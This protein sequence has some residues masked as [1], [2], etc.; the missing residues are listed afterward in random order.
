MNAP[1]EDIPEQ[2][3]P[4]D[5]GP[6]HQ[7]RTA[8]AKAGLS[9][10][11]VS[12]RL[13]L[14][15]RTLDMLE[16]EDFDDLPAPT[17]IRG[18]L[19]SYARLLGL[20]PEPI[21]EAFDRQ[22]YGPPALIADI[23]HR[24]EARSTDLWVVVL[25]VFLIALFTVLAAVWYQTN[26]SGDFAG[27]SPAEPSSASPPPADRSDPQA[28]NIGRT[29][30]S[31]QKPGD[32][33]SIPRTDGE[34]AE[35]TQTT[36]AQSSGSGQPPQPAQTP[37]KTQD[38]T[39]QTATN[40][41][42]GERVPDRAAPSEAS[43]SATQTDSPA[44]SSREALATRQTAASGIER[45]TTGT[46]SGAV[47]SSQ[48]RAA[49]TANDEAGRGPIDTVVMQFARDAWVEIYDAKGQRLYYNLARAGKRVEVEGARPMRVLLGYV[50][51]VQVEYNG[52]PFDFSSYISKGI[53]RFEMRP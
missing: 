40:T 24:S 11:E 35:A 20:P 39:L 12:A 7:L 21:V 1:S 38:G 33:D 47:P 8:R 41:P 30:R 3:L 29:E 43:V 27:T 4:I 6:G 19:R 34:P 18:Y 48:R 28:S 5:D 45:Q 15:R 50:K 10:E 13:H 53:A 2:G 26:K 32:A 17:F 9:L 31:N 42:T 25:T 52:A 37:A 51:G 49:T 23:A 16:N 36:G 22:G 14:D 44:G 46:S